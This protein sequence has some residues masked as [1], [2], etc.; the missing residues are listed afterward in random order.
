[1]IIKK[2]LKEYFRQTRHQVQ[3]AILLLTLGIGV[4][5]NLYVK[6]ASGP[7]AITIQRPPG[8]EGFLPI[9]ALMGWKH[10]LMTGNWDIV[11]PAA[12]VILG[13]AVMLSFFLRKTFCGWFCPIGTVSEWCWK[14]GQS[15]VGKE[16][17]IPSFIDLPLRSIKYLLL[18][19]FIWVVSMM[20][21]HQIAAFL[22][23]PYYALADVKMLYF[24]IRMTFITAV[25]LIG[26]VV[27]SFFFKNFWCRYLCPYGALL[28]LFSMISPTR[29]C[30]HETH[31]IDCGNCHRAC[32]SFLPVSKKITIRSPEC[33]GC[34]D[35][36]NACPAKD[37]LTFSSIGFSDRFWTHRKV[38]LIIIFSF[39]FAVCVANITGHW[40]SSITDHEFKIR[41]RTID[42]PENTHPTIDF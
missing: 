25:V 9:G 11:H 24:F 26:L 8:V 10:F 12:M 40:S 16:L 33:T 18:G 22:Q 42:A 7:N 20:D 29:I 23:S 34:L 31:C 13:Y 19:F 32:P 14:I 2:Y 27:L 4:Q 37:A 28:G 15:L 5:F 35:C 21:T 1:V 39:I 38:G 30:R 3:L 41:L 36:I 17:R 6:Q